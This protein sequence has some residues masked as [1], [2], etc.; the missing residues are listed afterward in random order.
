MKKIREKKTRLKG[1]FLNIWSIKLLRII[2]LLGVVGLLIFSFV[3]FLNR[4]IPAERIEVEGRVFDL[5]TEEPLEGVEVNSLIEGDLDILTD[6]QGEF[7][8]EVWNDDTLVLVGKDFFEE[9]KIPVKKRENIEIGIESSVLV[10][11]RQVEEAER[12]R[13]YRILYQ[14]LA[15]EQKEEWSEEEYLALKNSWRDS[16]S[17]EGLSGPISVEI[18]REV[19]R[20]GETYQTTIIYYWQEGESIEEE[21]FEF[22]FTK[23]QDFN[24]LD[25]SF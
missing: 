22:V 4:E 9:V 15:E 11:L 16:H 1:I 25:Q 7:S 8:L 12:F 10:F 6:A 21:T 3:K 19:D 2:L 14:F 5:D 23:Q 13:K 24:F 20:D 18:N 17:D